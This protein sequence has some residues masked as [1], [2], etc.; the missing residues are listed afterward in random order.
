MTKREKKVIE[1]ACAFLIALQWE[2]Q[3]PE[4]IKKRL[5]KEIEQ[6]KRILEW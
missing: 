3:L 4:Y 2:T 1:Q 6:L 5:E